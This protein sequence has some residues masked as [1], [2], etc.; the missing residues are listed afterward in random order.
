ME[1]ALL[2]SIIGPVYVITGLSLLFF[3]GQWAKVI[4]EFKKNHFSYLIGAY[5]NL[6][7][8]LI[9][10]NM[11]NVWTFNLW[12]IVT[13]TGWALILKGVFYFLAPGSWIKAILN[14]KVNQSLSWLAFWGFVM[15]VAGAALSYNSYFV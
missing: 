13:I 7:L 3:P 12:L 2:A 15:L 14:Q 8:G 9:V 1:K 4:E 11:F 5:V 10:V 6:V